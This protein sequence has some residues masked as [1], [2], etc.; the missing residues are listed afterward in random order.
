MR[1]AITI[2]LM[3]AGIV[4]VMAQNTNS[5][6]IFLE[7]GVGYGLGNS[8]TVIAAK[9]EN[10]EVKLT[11][12]E[13]LGFQIG[14]GYRYALNKT[15]AVE[16]KFKYQAFANNLKPTSMIKIMP[17]YKYFTP[18]STGGFYYGVNASVV[19]S[20]KGSSNLNGSVVTAD[21]LNPLSIG[22][23]FGVEMGYPLRRNQFVSFFWDYQYIK[24]NSIE[25]YETRDYGMLGLQYGYRF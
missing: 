13:G 22:F 3:L 20:S 5:S 6:G 10:N 17:G 21:F 24:G 8:P 19:I 11:K 25:G 12:A 1:I 9:I 16:M 23:G 18:K 7:G 4:N 15:S 2:I 14:T